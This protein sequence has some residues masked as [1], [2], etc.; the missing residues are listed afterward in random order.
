M[1]NEKGV[2]KLAGI[3]SYGLDCSTRDR[4]SQ[5]VI[6]ELDYEYDEPKPLAEEVDSN[7]TVYGI[8]TNVEKYVPWIKANSDYKGCEDSK[9]SFI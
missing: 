5:D 9:L 4:P 2:F 6:R 8:Y 7:A 1:S 3:T